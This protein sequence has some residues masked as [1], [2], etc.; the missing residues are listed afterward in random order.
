MDLTTGHTDL[1][2]KLREIPYK[3]A[4]RSDVG[5]RCLPGT[6]ADFL[7]YIIEWV[8]NPNS[9]RGLVLFG[10]AGTGKSSI[11]H[12]VAQR[13]QV[14]NRLTSF[15]VFL[16]AE[17]SKREDY[18]L[19]TTLVHDLSN[20][21]PSF[22]TALGK[23]IRD[24]K[25]LR[26]AQ[27]YHTLFESLLLQPLRDV[28]TVGPILIIID[29]LDESGDATGRNGL[30]IFLAEC[31]ASLPSNFR[32]LITS[33]SEA[34]IMLPFAGASGSSF[35][36]VHMNDSNL[37]ARTDDDIHIYLEKYLPS[38]T[39]TQYGDKLVKKAEGL[40]Q[41]AAVACGYIS[42]PPPGLTKNDCIHG[43]LK[44][45]ADHEELG[46]A[47]GPLYNLYQ[48]VLEGY[49]LARIVQHRFRS[50]MGQLLA[51]FEP[52]SIDSLTA[53]RRYHLDDRDDDSV[54]AI[55]RHLGSL[56]SNVT[57]TDHTLPIV[58]LHTSFR[59]FLTDEKMSGDFYIDLGEAHHQLAHSCL[60]LMLHDLKF[61]ICNI[62]SSYLPNSKTPDPHGCISPAL[63]Y[64]CR[65]WDD[66]L[67]RLPFEQ[68]VFAKLR[69]LFEK[70][71]LFW[72]EVLSLTS[73]VDLAPPA[74]LSL[75]TWL[76][77]GHHN[78]VYPIV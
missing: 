53:L 76:A 61:N 35:E 24:N 17:R 45:S 2:E 47:L 49:F 38:K 21:Y 44:P 23:A 33:R 67:E 20:R 64:A 11:A 34:D 51:A 74:L 22:K 70:K 66:H 14:M 12:E 58:P 10:Q 78:E 9:K 27:D 72:L 59:D 5:R 39:F 43:L 37:A 73:T 29:A 40:F 31:L 6:R 28:H 19:F 69:L 1:D 25:Y 75:N 46:Q 60:G 7:D 68:D 71:F 52:L 16:R 41:W 32:V 56:L 4:R 26:A 18:L 48:Q 77:S 65:F 57:L 36:I 62:E 54:I 63:F 15:F 3:G 50:V 13:F 42:Y 8:D 30:H 55:V